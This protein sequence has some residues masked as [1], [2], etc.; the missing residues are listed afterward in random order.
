MSLVRSS[1]EYASVVWDPHLVKHKT[2]LEKIQRKA[3]RWISSDFQRHS[4]VTEMLRILN[5]EPL[6]DR[7]RTNR[8]VFLF[9]ILNDRVA[10]SPTDLS[11]ELNPR[12][13][14]GLATQQKLIVPFCAT[15]E[16][17]SHFAARTIPEW[18]RLPQKTTAADSVDAFKSRL[19]SPA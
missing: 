17:K 15:T 16:L 3:A 11:L 5:L 6:E 19:L 12:A 10:L 14:R 13:T 4:S 1:L 9:K 7:R 2:A 18:N 8:L